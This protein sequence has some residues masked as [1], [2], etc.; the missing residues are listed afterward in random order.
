MTSQ[1]D[2]TLYEQLTESCPNCDS[3]NCLF[4]ETCSCNDCGYEETK[5][6]KV[7]NPGDRESDGV[8]YR[9]MEG[10]SGTGWHRVIVN[11]VPVE[12]PAGYIALCTTY[13]GTSTVIARP[14]FLNKENSKPYR[15][16]HG[17]SHTKPG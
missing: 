11:G 17:D 7:L 12:N 9:W 2:Q 13:E 15:R 8:V 6:G 14:D 5:D 10:H 3:M 1:I 4:G 16:K